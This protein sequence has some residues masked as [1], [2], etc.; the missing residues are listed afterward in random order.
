[1]GG[2][3]FAQ[4]CLAIVPDDLV[5]VRQVTHVTID[6]A[7]H[8]F[9]V[10]IH[11]CPLRAA[12]QN[13]G[14]SPSRQKPPLTRSQPMR[15]MPAVAQQAGR[16]VLSHLSLGVVD[17]AKAGAFYD[18]VLGA[19]GYVRVWSSDGGVGY[20]EA[21]GNDKLA[22]FARPGATAPGAG[23]HLAFA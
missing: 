5:P 20:G 2:F 6:P 1:G 14:L 21:G 12:W 19:L 8:C 10:T 15:T 9:L 22:L 11:P 13:G 18:G 3:V 7:E 23:F 17:L 4:R 16:I